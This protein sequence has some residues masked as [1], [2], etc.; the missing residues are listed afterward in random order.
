MQENE[1]NY[2]WESDIE[3]TNIKLS[4]FKIQNIYLVTDFLINARC[5]KRNNS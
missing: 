3:V 4:P 5:D 2:K 1:I